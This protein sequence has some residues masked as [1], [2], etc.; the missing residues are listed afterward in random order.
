[1]EGD[2][3]D[4]GTDS[5]FEGPSAALDRGQAMQATITKSA[6]DLSTAWVTAVLQ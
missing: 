6:R 4:E 2:S 3:N 1:M 5:E